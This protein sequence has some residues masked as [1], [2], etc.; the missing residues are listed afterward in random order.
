MM[1]VV[2]KSSFLRFYEM[3]KATEDRHSGIHSDS[4]SKLK[5]EGNCKI[6]G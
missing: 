4:E 3:E 1:E 2:N 5:S 6:I